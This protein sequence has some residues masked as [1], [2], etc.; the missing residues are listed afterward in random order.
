[1]AVFLVI[2]STNNASD[3]SGDID[4][5]NLLGSLVQSH[6]ALARHSK[7]SRH[8]AILALDFLLQQQTNT[9][10]ATDEHMHIHRAKLAAACTHADVLKT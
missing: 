8:Q 1:M 9:R 10:K 4:L 6:H 7:E 5:P 3:D 2:F